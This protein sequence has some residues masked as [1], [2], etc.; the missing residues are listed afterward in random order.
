MLTYI[1]KV[2]ILKN[3]GDNMERKFTLRAMI[4]TTAICGVLISLIYL[5]S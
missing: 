5:L 4:V 3:K 1:G 2:I